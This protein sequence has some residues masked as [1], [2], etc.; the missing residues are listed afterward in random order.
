MC[1]GMRGRNSGTLRRINLDLAFN[2]DFNVDFNLDLLETF[3][4][5][6]QARV[7]ANLKKK[8][9]GFVSSYLKLGTLGITE[10]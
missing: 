8:A 2:V 1:L 7:N 3:G 4:T 9:D 10:I 5:S 6:E